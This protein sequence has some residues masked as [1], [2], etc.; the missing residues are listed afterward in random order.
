MQNRHPSPIFDSF[1][2]SRF[3][4]AHSPTRLLARKCKEPTN[5]AIKEDCDPRRCES[6]LHTCYKPESI[7]GL[8]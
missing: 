8:C 2:W 5:M 4:P 3:Q 7:I 6:K 1:P